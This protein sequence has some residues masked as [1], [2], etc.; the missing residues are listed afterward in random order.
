MFV[1]KRKS[2]LQNNKKLIGRII[3]KLTQNM[4]VLKSVAKKKNLL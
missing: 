1:I 2:Y 3:K 4:N